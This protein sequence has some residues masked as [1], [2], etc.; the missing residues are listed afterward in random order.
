MLANL[1]AAF[2]ATFVEALVALG[3][4]V[5]LLHWPLWTALPLW[6]LLYLISCRMWPFRICWR[7]NGARNRSDGRG[8]LRDRNCQVCGAQGRRPRWGAR[9]VAPGKLG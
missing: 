5:I 8:N 7:C 1:W 3:V 4:V 6:G 2:R 9:L